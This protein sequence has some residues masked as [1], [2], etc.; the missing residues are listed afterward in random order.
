MKK[1]QCKYTELLLFVNSLNAK[2]C[3]ATCNKI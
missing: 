3:F 2:L 1:P